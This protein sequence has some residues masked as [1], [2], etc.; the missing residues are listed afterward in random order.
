M[1]LKI[2]KLDHVQLSIPAGCEA[3]ARKFYRDVL[4]LTE[5][6]KPSALIVNGGLWFAVADIQLH[7]GIEDNHGKVK[8]HPAFEV[9]DLAQARTYLA[10]HDVEIKEEIPIPGIR[11]FSFYDPFG[12]RIELLQKEN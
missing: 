8:R 7:L 4:G 1:S 11:R 9:E 3:A 6:E 12:N 10:S 2:K 5:V